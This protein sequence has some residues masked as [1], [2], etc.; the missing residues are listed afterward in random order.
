M[1]ERRMEEEEW[2]YSSGYSCWL[3]VHVCELPSECCPY[4]RM[5]LPFIVLWAKMYIYA[6]FVII[7]IIATPTP[8][9]V[10]VVVVGRC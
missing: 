4:E 10:V 2:V 3:S 1:D 7:S 8:T 9:D 6:T 5:P